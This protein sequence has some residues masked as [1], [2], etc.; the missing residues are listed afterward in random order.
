M[1]KAKHVVTNERL[2]EAGREQLVGEEEA[3]VEVEAEAEQLFLTML[4]TLMMPLLL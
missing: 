2:V 3:E 4:S 1:T